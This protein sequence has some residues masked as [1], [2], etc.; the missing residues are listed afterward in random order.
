MEEGKRTKNPSRV[1]VH[2]FSFPFAPRDGQVE[3]PHSAQPVLQGS[4]E[5]HQETKE[6]PPHFHQRDGSQVSEGP[7]RWPSRRTTQRT[8]SPTRLTRMASRNLGG[9]ATLPPKGWCV[10]LLLEYLLDGSQVSEEPEVFLASRLNVPGAWQMPQTVHPSFGERYF[11]R[12]T[13]GG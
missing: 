2:R 9:T 11:S 13:K 12:A 7:E 4:Q 1:V 10:S 8:T 6:A 3:E 5:W